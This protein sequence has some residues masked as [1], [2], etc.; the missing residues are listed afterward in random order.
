MKQKRCAFNLEWYAAIS[1]KVEKLKSFGPIGEVD[2][3]EWIENIVMGKKDKQ[4]VASLS[5]LYRLEQSMS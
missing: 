3:L 5:E 2:Y 1:E 4:E